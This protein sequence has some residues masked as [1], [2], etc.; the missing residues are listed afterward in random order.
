[1]SAAEMT[2]ALA[3]LNP[4]NYQAA[5]KFIRYLLSTQRQSVAMVNRSKRFGVA[6]GKLYVPDDIDFCNEEVADLF[7]V[8]K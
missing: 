3:G 4:E 2:Q 7:G 1:M 6:K 8:Q 5:M